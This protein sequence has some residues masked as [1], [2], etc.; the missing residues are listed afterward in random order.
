MI[1]VARHAGVIGKAGDNKQ[2]RGAG[3]GAALHNV[4]APNRAHGLAVIGVVYS[5]AVLNAGYG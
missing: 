3:H 1:H 2:V 5:N 4:G